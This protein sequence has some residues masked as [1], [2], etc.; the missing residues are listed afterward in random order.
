MWVVVVSPASRLMVSFGFLAFFA[1]QFLVCCGDF[2]W[3][4]GGGRRSFRRRTV[5]GPFREGARG[6]R[7]GDGLGIRRVPRPA[8]Q[9]GC[10]CKQ[11]PS[12]LGRHASPGGLA[13]GGLFSSPVAAPYGGITKGS[14]RDLPVM[15][16]EAY[17]SE[18]PAFAGLRR[19]R[20]RARTPRPYSPSLLGSGGP[21]SRFSPI[22]GERSLGGQTRGGEG[23]GS[24][25]AAGRTM[26]R[27]TVRQE[28][29]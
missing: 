2:G 16:G 13:H 11:D 23:C 28:Q 9:E 7:D 5:P 24:S 15:K 3:Y 14:G 18:E 20:Q 27:L 29:P 8:S 19:V 17:Q 21:E 12:L 10:P 1:F 26:H 22:D 25:A 6:V 4:A